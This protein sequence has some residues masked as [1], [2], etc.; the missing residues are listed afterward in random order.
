MRDV[1]EGRITVGRAMEEVRGLPF[2]DLGFAKVDTHR[3]LRR[4]FPEVVYCPGKTDAQ[5]SS[6][7]ERMAADSSVALATRATPET[8][9]AVARTLKENPV[10]YHDAARMIY[11]LTGFAMVSC[12]DP[13]MGVWVEYPP[14]RVKG[15]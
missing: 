9:R 15:E 8:Y 13:I 3:G 1:R 11:D 4:G 2:E 10:A 5:I 7:L 12:C 14:R 6:I